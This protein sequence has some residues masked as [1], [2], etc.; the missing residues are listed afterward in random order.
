[1]CDSRMRK[2][3]PMMSIDI[4]N[5][6]GRN[7]AEQHNAQQSLRL[8]LETAACEAGLDV[9]AWST[10]WSGDGAFV[11]LPA[12]TPID[13]LA[14]S[15]IQE[16]NVLLGTRNRRP[17]PAPWTTI[18]LRVSL[19]EG[20]VRTDGA[21]GIPGSHA[22]QVNR[23]VDAEALRVALACCHGVDLAVIFSER[24]FNDYLTDGYGTLNPAG[25]RPIRVMAKKNQ[26]LAYLY[27]PNCDLYKIH[28]LNRFD[29]AP[30]TRN[31]DSALPRRHAASAEPPIGAP[32]KI[33]Y[34]S[35][36]TITDSNVNETHSGNIQV[37]EINLG[38][39]R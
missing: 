17:L 31:E 12:G 4:E 5:Y 25:F 16:L 30:A 22:V 18:R 26:Y 34:G 3:H 13:Q 6:S 24:V 1:M 28:E 20:P 27:I 2:I 7:E 14:G 21:T 10:Q 37:G 33:V 36:H 15:F 23:L 9:T 35:A 19:H 32:R 8:V 38:R 29:E 39:P 11:V